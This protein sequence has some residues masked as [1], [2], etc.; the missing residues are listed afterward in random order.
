MLLDDE[1]KRTA[2]VGH[3][4]NMSEKTCILGT[5]TSWSPWESLLGPVSRTKRANFN[6]C[7]AMEARSL[8]PKVLGVEFRIFS[9]KAYLVFVTCD[10]KIALGIEGLK[11]AL[12][13]LVQVSSLV[14][15]VCV[16]LLLLLAV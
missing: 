4:I 2:V 15:A 7:L 5:Q 16:V 6:A 3:Q 8:S 11:L 12:L 14:S 13:R 9:F 10:G 1:P